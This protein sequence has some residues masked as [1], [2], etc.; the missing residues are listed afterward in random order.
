MFR[1]F[2]DFISNLREGDEALKRRWLFVFSVPTMLIV[3]FLWVVYV[4]ATLPE[5]NVEAVAVSEPE[6][7]S[8]G[9]TASVLRTGALVIVQESLAR[10]DRAFKAVKGKLL[11][12]N[13]ITFKPEAEPNFV[14]TD[15]PPIPTT[16]LR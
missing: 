14:V 5:T 2:R 13:V 12:R 4:R 16:P 3:V 11:E 6:R 8:F 9:E 7:F 10:A 15:L 1:N